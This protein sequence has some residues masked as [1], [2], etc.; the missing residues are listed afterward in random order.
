MY[1]LLLQAMSLSELAWVVGVEVDVLA[2]VGEEVLW[3]QK[4]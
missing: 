4:G 3:R 1:G 2:V